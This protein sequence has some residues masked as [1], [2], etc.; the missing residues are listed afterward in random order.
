VEKRGLVT[1]TAANLAILDTSVYVD[2]LRF[3]HFKQEILDYSGSQIRYSLQRS[4]FGGIIERRSIQRNEKVCR[5]P[6]EKSPNYRPNQRE[7]V[8]SGRIVNR[9]VAAKGYDI[10]KTRE[11]HFDV[12]I[13]LTARRI[14]AYLITCNVDDFTTVREFF[15]FNLVCW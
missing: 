3:G 10:H 8:Q 14:G 12:L 4:G 5:R 9:L 13:A 1:L 15:D 6:G 11:V 7:W 2:N